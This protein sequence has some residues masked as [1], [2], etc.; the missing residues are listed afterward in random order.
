VTDDRRA[1][2]RHPVLFAAG[3]GGMLALLTFAVVFW[4]VW[5]L[6][7]SAVAFVGTAVVAAVLDGVRAQQRKD[8]DA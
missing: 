3:A 6:L 7:A 5:W 1:S 8:S 4:D 2:A